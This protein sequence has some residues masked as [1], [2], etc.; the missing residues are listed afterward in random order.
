MNNEEKKHLLISVQ[1]AFRFVISWGIENLRPTKLSS[2]ET[3]KMRDIVSFV[4]DKNMNGLPAP[5][6]RALNVQVV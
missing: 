5:L 6:V 1:I 4:E 3:F 2:H